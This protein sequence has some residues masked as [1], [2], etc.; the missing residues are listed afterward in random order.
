MGGAAAE[1]AKLRLV[2]IGVATLAGVVEERITRQKAVDLR[3]P[4]ASDVRRGD[5]LQRCAKMK[6]P[7]VQRQATLGW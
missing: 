7:Q 4:P 5:I 3:R 6:W 1:A 2:V